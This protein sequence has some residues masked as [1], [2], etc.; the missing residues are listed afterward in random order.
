MDGKENERGSSEY[1]WRGL[2]V[3]GDDLSKNMILVVTPK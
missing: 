1:G 2:R 3:F